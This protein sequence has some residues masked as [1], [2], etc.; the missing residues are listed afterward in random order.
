MNIMQNIEQN[1]SQEELSVIEWLTRMLD[2]NNIGEERVDVINDMLASYIKSIAEEHPE[3]LDSLV[4]YLQEEKNRLAFK[5]S[6]NNI[7]LVVTLSFMIKEEQSYQQAIRLVMFHCRQDD[8]FAKFMK[9]YYLDNLDIHDFSGIVQ[10]EKEYQAIEQRLDYFKTE[11]L[12]L[13]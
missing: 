9:L 8:S 1:T 12:S 7:N 10:N 5:S 11:Y 13:V 2:F 3:H 6:M 4:N